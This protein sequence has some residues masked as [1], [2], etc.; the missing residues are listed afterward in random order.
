MSPPVKRAP[1]GKAKGHA[2]GRP[3]PVATIAKARGKRPRARPDAAVRK[4]AIQPVSR[5]ARRVPQSPNRTPA[6]EDATL[7][8]GSG[9]RGIRLL[10]DYWKAEERLQNERIGHAVVIYGST[11]IVAPSVANARLDEA[12]RRLAQ[13]PHDASRRRAVAI[14]SRLVEQSAYYRVAREFGRIVA[15]ADRC[16]RT[17][18]L[19][20]V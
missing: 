17:A 19:A 2:R 15:H 18:R 16:T 11:R 9:M 4:D 12:N 8:Q 7:L 10:L 5:R 13:R 6:D 14:A 1:A 20:I 3:V